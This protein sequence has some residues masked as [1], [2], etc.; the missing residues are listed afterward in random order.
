MRL[1]IRVKPRL[2]ST[3]TGQGIIASARLGGSYTINANY[4]P[5][6]ETTSVSDLTQYIVALQN[7]DDGSFSKI[8]LDNLPVGVVDWTNVTS[9]PSTFTPSAHTHPSSD[10]SDSTSAGRGILTAADAAAQ[11]TLLGISGLVATRRLLATN[12]T[13]YVATT[14][15]DT[16]GNGLIGTPY[17]TPQKAWDV[18][19]RTLDLGGYTLTIQIADGTYSAGINTLEKPAV[20]GSVVILGNITTPANVVINASSGDAIEVSNSRVT[21][22][23]MRLANSNGSGLHVYHHGMVVIG[24][25]MQFGTCSESHIFC[26]DEGHIAVGNGYTIVGDAPYHWLV[27]QGGYLSCVVKTITASGTRAF[28]SAFIYCLRGGIAEVNG[29]TYT[30]TFT[31]KRFIIDQGGN[32]NTGNNTLTNL[33]GDAAGEINCGVYGDVTGSGRPVSFTPTYF[34]LST[35]GSTTYTTQ[36]GSYIRLGNIVFFRA[37]VTWTAASGTGQA[38]I[39]NLPFTSVDAFMNVAYY[40][41]V[42]VGNHKQLVAF[43][44]FSQTHAALYACDPAGGAA[45]SVVVEAA[46]EIRLSGFYFIS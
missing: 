7:K 15:N 5:L 26:D 37:Q 13:I 4:R 38:A 16:T 17:A 3:I 24:A 31:G 20:G 10:I 12:E 39:G 35:A 6:T 23:G 8:T 1:S 32:V 11:R 36:T 43:V 22:Q 25:S 34:G 21:I 46:G 45:A 18:L 33:P 30:G 9:K 40:D 28:S 41:N 29:N 2:P 14:G 44:P 42:T 27:A 19:A